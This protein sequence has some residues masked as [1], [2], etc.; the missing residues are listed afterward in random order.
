MIST[1]VS[2]GRGSSGIPQAASKPARDG[3]V[4]DGSIVGIDHR[5]QPGVRGALHVVLAAQR[6]QARHR[7]GRPAR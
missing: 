6:V 1:T 3:V 5:D 4:A 7:A 2:P